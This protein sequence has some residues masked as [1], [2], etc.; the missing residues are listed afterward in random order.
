MPNNNIVPNETDMPGN[1][2]VVLAR[3]CYALNCELSDII[4]YVKIQ[5]SMEEK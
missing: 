2:T 3:F 4:E 1:N 5:V